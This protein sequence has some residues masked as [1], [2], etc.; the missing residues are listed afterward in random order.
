MTG[1]PSEPGLLPRTLDA[2]F[3]SLSPQQL[4]DLDIKP[5]HYSNVMYLTKA[6]V[7]RERQLKESM[8]KMVCVL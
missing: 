7:E 8:L 1:T 5:K 4:S 3:S 2:I 6:D